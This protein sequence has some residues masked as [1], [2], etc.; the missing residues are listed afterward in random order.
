MAILADFESQLARSVCDTELPDHRQLTD[1]LTTTAKRI[2]EA[3]E[4]DPLDDF[5]AIFDSVWQ[6]ANE[7]RARFVSDLKDNVVLGINPAATDWAPLAADPKKRKEAQ[8]FVDSNEALDLLAR[9]LIVKAHILAGL[10]PPLSSTQQ[11]AADVISAFRVPLEMYNHIVRRIA[12]R[13]GSNME[14]RKRSNAVWDFNI[15]FAIGPT[16]RVNGLPVVMITDD[17]GIRYAAQRAGCAQHVMDLNT[18]LQFVA[19]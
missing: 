6:A 16:Q 10:T 4:T 18:Y 19:V 15:S 13:D 7:I 11:E 17:G 5:A 2:G 9:A 12:G 8:T 3:I 1:V 14:K